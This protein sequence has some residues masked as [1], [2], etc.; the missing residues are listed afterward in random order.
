MTPPPTRSEESALAPDELYLSTKPDKHKYV[1]DPI[2]RW[3]E[4]QKVYP[5]L[6]QMAIDF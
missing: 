3:K 2:R 5:R 4:K 6:S 1:A